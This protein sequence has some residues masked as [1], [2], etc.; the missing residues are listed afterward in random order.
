MDLNFIAV[1][2]HRPPTQASYGTEKKGGAKAWNPEPTNQNSMPNAAGVFVDPFW[3]GCYCYSEVAGAGPQHA[4]NQLLSSDKSLCS[5]FKINQRIEPQQA[6]SMQR[7]AWPQKQAH[8]NHS[9]CNSI[10]IHFFKVSKESPPPSCSSQPP[11]TRRDFCFS[12]SIPLVHDSQKRYNVYGLFNYNVHDQSCDILE[13]FRLVVINLS[14]PVVIPRSVTLLRIQGPSS[15]H[16]KSVVKVGTFISKIMPKLCLGADNTSFRNQRTIARD[17]NN[18]LFF[19][20]LH[21]LFDVKG[22]SLPPSVACY[23]LCNA[24]IINS[25]SPEDFCNFTCGVSSHPP[26]LR[27]PNYQYLNIPSMLRV[28]RDTIAAMTMCIYEGKYWSDMSLNQPTEDQPFPLSFLPGNR[29]FQKDDC[30]GR[31]TQTQEM[32][33]LL[34]CMFQA[35]QI[36]GLDDFLQSIVNVPTQ[37]SRLALDRATLNCIVKS[38][39]NFGRLLHENIIEVHTVVGDVCFA[40]FTSDVKVDSKE[41]V[42]SGH[43][44]GI[45]I[46]NDGLTHECTILEG[47]GWER[48]QL[49]CDRPISKHEM[50][51]AQLLSQS[52][53]RQGRPMAVCGQLHPT[54]ENTV[55]KHMYLGNGCLFFTVPN[56]STTGGANMQYGPGLE[57]FRQHVYT[58]PSLPNNTTTSGLF[59]ISTSDFLQELTYLEDIVNNKNAQPHIAAIADTRRKLW[60]FINIFDPEIVQNVQGA[61]EMLQT[62]QNISAQMPFTRRCLATPPKSEG[63]LQTLMQ[64]WA[65]LHQSKIPIKTGSCS[66][67]LLSIEYGEYDAKDSVD[68]L[69][70]NLMIEP[71]SQLSE[72]MQR[73]KLEVYSFMRSNILRYTEN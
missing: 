70:K 41:A 53:K 55:Y 40:A 73:G 48:S 26:Q 57:S 6:S 4:M 69:K 39:V 13:N 9:I 46:Y 43:S 2:V 35:S 18:T 62:Y 7:C 59:K 12:S 54:K 60:K 58:Y 51:F 3:T 17:R 66:G 8:H 42:D 37:L 36:H 28:L 24:L 68:C 19:Q 31:I 14:A 16:H 65:I 20:D 25:I 56:T 67:I 45:I 23:T 47:T 72:I 32:V 64:S 5:I 11:E 22:T 15:E 44:F 34:K 71:G 10:K 1:V 63:V 21:Q 38:C 52:M 27:T 33:K 29:I 49:P 50:V 61:S 30:E